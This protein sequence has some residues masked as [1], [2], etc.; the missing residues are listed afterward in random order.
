MFFS[1][2]RRISTFANACVTTL[3]HGASLVATITKRGERWL[4]QIRRKGVPPSSRTFGSKTDAKAWATIEESRIERAEA[5]S[6]RRLLAATT[7]GAI[8]RRYREEVTPLKRSAATEIQRLKQLERDTLAETALS[9]LD[10]TTL[11]AY[12]DR[13]LKSVRPATVRREL[14][15]ISHSLEVARKEWGFGLPNN[16]AKDI[17]QPPLSRGRHRRLE[18]GEWLRLLAALSAC[19]NQRV[20]P[21]VKLA[22]ET[23]M[24]RGELVALRWEN[25]NLGTATLHIPDTKTGYAR[26]IPLTDNAVAILK[27]LEGRA[28]CVFAITTNAFKLAWVRVVDRAGLTD[29]RFH[30][31]RHEAISRFAEMGLSTVELSVI[32]GHRDPRMLFRY[33]HLRP[34]DL[35]KKLAGRSWEQEVGSV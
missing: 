13:R 8:L 29:F 23:G 24:R 11:A 20:A 12:R 14:A 26:T 30:D 2:A 25:I 35:A 34:A 17:R 7:Y 19:R 6:P 5:V 4:V 31:L 9:N 18:K 32:S 21:L 33:A 28:G 10:S 22:I 16:P 3:S 1:G 15:I 27:A